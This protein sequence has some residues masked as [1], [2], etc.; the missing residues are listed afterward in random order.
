MT[1]NRQHAK[2]LR[3]VYRSAGWPYLDVIDI[4]P[5][6]ASL[7][8]RTSPEATSSVRVTDQGLAY[9]AGAAQTNRKVS[10][11]LQHNPTTTPLN[12][13]VI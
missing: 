10:F 12:T 3:E 5:L 9:P 1:L 6:A 13:V 8:E 4:E 2:R 11:D 7:L